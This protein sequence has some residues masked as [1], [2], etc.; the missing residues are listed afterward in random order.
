SE[1]R[2]EL[3]LFLLLLLEEVVHGLQDARLGRPAD[4]GVAGHRGL[5]R[6]RGDGAAGARLARLLLLVLPLDLLPLGRLDLAVLRAELLELLGD[7]ED[8]ARIEL[9]GGE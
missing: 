5:Q 4:R 9:L 8:A 7:R 6:T 3:H 1:Q 2:L